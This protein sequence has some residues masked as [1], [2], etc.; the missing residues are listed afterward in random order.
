MNRLRHLLHIPLRIYTRD[1]LLNFLLEKLQKRDGEAEAEDA[2]YVHDEVE[3]LMELWDRKAWT[4]FL[5]FI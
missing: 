2:L 4:M 3:I 1:L 5:S